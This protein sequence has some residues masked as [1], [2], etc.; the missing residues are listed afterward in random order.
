MAPLPVSTKPRYFLEV[1]Q[2]FGRGVV[3]DPDIR[4][5]FTRSVPNGVRGARLRCDCGNIYDARL[6]ALRPFT[7]PSRRNRNPV[8]TRSCGCLHD[9]N[10]REQG[11][12]ATLTHGLEDHPLYGTWKQMLHR[13]ENPA[14]RS[15]RNYGGRGIKVCPE[16]HDITVFI[17]W[18][19]QNL[20]SRPQGM[21]LDR[22]NNH[23]SYE[24]GNMRWATRSEQN[25][26]QRP[27]IRRRQPSPS[28]PE[29]CR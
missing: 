20:G 11:K 24:P 2:R 25:L 21:T 22:V 28:L 27:G 9:E 18:I 6:T 5:G 23:G 14:S 17:A 4:T 1:G 29:S 16:W 19:E 8:N 12:V 15:Y 10:S 7:G 3:I 13:C 26:N